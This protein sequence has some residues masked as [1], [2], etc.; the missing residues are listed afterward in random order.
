MLCVREDENKVHDTGRGKLSGAL[1]A[2]FKLMWQNARL[3]TYRLFTDFIR[4]A[5]RRGLELEGK[6]GRFE[7]VLD[8]RGIL[9]IA[10]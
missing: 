2:L 10:V 9:Q 5:W 6:Q 8:A 7:T 3:H 1:H 4:S